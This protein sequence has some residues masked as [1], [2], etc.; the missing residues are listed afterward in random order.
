MKQERADRIG[1][2]MLAELGTMI[3]REVKDPRIGF[4]S[5]TRVEVSRDLAKAKVFVS[6]LD[7]AQ[8]EDTL[9]GLKSAGRFLRGEVARRL[10]LRVAPE[11]EFRLDHSIAD[12]VHIH[13]LLKQAGMI[14]PDDGDTHEP[15][16]S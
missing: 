9:N 11:L 6:V 15:S 1:E 8:V 4:V 13:Q 14:Q 3:Q 10:G 2:A 5:I 16:G 7:P 12:S